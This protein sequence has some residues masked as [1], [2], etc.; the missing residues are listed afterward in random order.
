MMEIYDIE[1]VIIVFKRQ[2]QS[3]KVRETESEIIKKTRQITTI[4]RKQSEENKQIKCRAD[5][6]KYEY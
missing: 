2:L 6:L 5:S 4:R 3:Q 1:K